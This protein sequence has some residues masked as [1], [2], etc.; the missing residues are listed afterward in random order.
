VILP[1]PPLLP[2]PIPAPP[3]LPIAVTVPPFIFIVPPSMNELRKRI[4][5][6]GTEDE[7]A[8][9]TRFRNAYKELN[10]IS[11]Y[12]YVVVNDK[13]ELATKKIEAIITAEKCSVARNTEIQRSVIEGDD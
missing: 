13:V 7:E 8:I 6:R 1:A 10:F 11:R 5:G 9:M 12:N 3:V 2:P 4:V